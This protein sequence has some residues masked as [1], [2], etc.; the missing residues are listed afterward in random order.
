MPQLARGGFIDSAGVAFLH[1]GETVVP[2]DFANNL[3]QQ[4]AVGD[5]RQQALLAA[6]NSTLQQGF[7]GLRV[8]LAENLS[9][10]KRTRAK[11]PS[12][13]AA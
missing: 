8:D 4:I 13:P 11:A 9:A 1:P 3:A 12:Q 5:A 7:G 6:I 10:T 2:A